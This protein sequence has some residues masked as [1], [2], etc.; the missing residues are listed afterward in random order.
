MSITDTDVDT[1]QDLRISTSSS[2][3][4]SRQSRL[5]CTLYKSGNPNP[6]AKYTFQAPEGPRFPQIFTP[7]RAQ[8]TMWLV[9]NKRKGKRCPILVP[10]QPLCSGTG[11]PCPGRPAHAYGSSTVIGSTRSGA[12]ASGFACPT[13][14]GLATTHITAWTRVV[15]KSVCAG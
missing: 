13:A 12:S 10:L 9:H 15:F 6:P 11:R 1:I 14:A 5:V 4:T 8:E 3:K 7:D 2:A